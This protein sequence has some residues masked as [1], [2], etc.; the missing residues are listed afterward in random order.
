MPILAQATP[1]Q[2]ANGLRRI[3]RERAPVRLHLHNRSQNFRDIF[4][5]ECLLPRQ[6]FIQHSAEGKDVCRLG[7]RLAASLFWTHIGSGAHNHAMHRR[8]HA[9][10][11]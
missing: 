10:R 3:C 9:E 11:G 4:A 2:H 7:Y 5:L 6:Q 8:I 1:E